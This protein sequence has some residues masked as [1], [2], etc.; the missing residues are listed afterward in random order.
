MCTTLVR[1]DPAAAWPAL[2]AFVRDED[3]HRE[4]DPPGFWWPEQ[5]T[6][7]GGRDRRAGGTW[8]AVDVATGALAFLL[9]RFEP[10][11]MDVHPVDP[12][13][14]GAIP[15]R[16]LEAGEAFD[17]DE[18]PL[19]HHEPFHLTR[20]TRAGATHWQ[21]DGSRLEADELGPGTHVVASRGEQLNGEHERR[22][23]ELARFADAAVPD[24]LPELASAEAW[25]PWI[26]L[27]DG[28]TAQPDAFDGL[29]VHSTRERPG[30]GT[31]G[32]T[33][34]ALGADGR[35]RMDVNHTQSV[36]P[37]AWTNVDVR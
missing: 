24:P 10:E 21:W 27:L 8:L 30:F 16:A 36:D 33:L 32:A 26:S 6:V 31:V 7:L 25:G 19:E 4:T 2:V 15:L 1:F 3:R 17:P 9:N 35:V 14:R 34:V 13:T 18:L 28:R 11:L 20:V 23:R 29:V 12:I 22:V 5:P 37:S